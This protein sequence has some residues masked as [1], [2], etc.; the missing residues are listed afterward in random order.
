MDEAKSFKTPCK[1]DERKKPGLVFG[2]PT[3]FM[4]PASPFMKKL[5]YGTGVSVYLMKRSPRGLSQSPWAVKKINAKLNNM[6]QNIYEQ[7][8]NEEAIILKNLQHPNII[9]YRAFTKAKDG[10]MCLAMEYGGDKSLND[11]IELKHEKGEGSFPAATILKVALHMA[12][13]LKYLHN[14]KKL[15]HGD[16]KSSNVVIKGDFETIKI[17]DVGVSLPLDENMMVSDPTMHYIGT[18]PWKPKEALDEGGIITDKSDIF[19][20][21]LTLWEMM[22][23]TIPH[24]NLPDKDDDESFEEDDFDDDAYYEALGTRPPLNMEELDESYQKV[25]ELF[26]VCTNED[27]KERPSAAQIVEVVEAH[28]QE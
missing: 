26:S 8:L 2:T 12:R 28:V 25:I 17:C 9:G 3:S 22:T 11:L 6:H 14:E 16:I 27:P 10:S 15:L 18:E 21:G 4:I 24:V 23:L 5:G 7:R 20:F 13:G 19:A 1:Q